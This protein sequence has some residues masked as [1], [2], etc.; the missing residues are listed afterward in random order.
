MDIS[1]LISFTAVSI[2]LTLAPGPDIIYVI[3]QSIAAGKKAGIATALGL[4]TGLI[5]HT[6]AASLEFLKYS[7]SQLLRS[8]F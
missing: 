5:V 1:N 3:T 2:L 4:C 6:T 8:E 7:Y